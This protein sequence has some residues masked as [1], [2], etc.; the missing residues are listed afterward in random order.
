MQKVAPAITVNEGAR[1]VQGELL[2]LTG[3]G[4]LPAEQ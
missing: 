2:E 4:R 1:S 3:L